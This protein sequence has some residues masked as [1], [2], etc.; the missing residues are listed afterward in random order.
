MPPVVSLDFDDHLRL[1]LPRAE[2]PATMQFVAFNTNVPH[3][4]AE[5]DYAHRVKELTLGIEF[6]TSQRHG[7]NSGGPNLKLGTINALLEAVDPTTP[8]NAPIE[9]ASLAGGALMQFDRVKGEAQNELTAA[10][11][12]SGGQPFSAEGGQP[13]SAEGCCPL[14]QGVSWG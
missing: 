3:V 12:H 4:L 11:V 5:S 8:G 1:P 10:E 14:K 7:I 2:L 9:L 13:C 6:L